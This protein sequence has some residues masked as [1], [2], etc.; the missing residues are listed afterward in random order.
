MAI[1]GAE[2]T[3]GGFGIAAGSPAEARKQV[4]LGLS[5]ELMKVPNRAVWCTEL[6]HK[7]MMAMEMNGFEFPFSPEQTRV[8]MPSLHSSKV[9]D[10]L[11]SQGGLCRTVRNEWPVVWFER[12]YEVAIGWTASKGYEAER[13]LEVVNDGR[14]LAR[15]LVGFDFMGTWPLMESVM[16]VPEAGKKYGRATIKGVGVD[17]P[18]K[19]AVDPGV[20]DLIEGGALGDERGRGVLK[21]LAVSLG[22]YANVQPG[23]IGERLEKIDFVV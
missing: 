14:D 6:V 8:S 17:L 9:R 19:F 7:M 20:L 12:P 10:E 1:D 23:L 15:R 11:L 22:R 2:R 4:R 16:G 13:H 3:P 5:S 18:W 21:A